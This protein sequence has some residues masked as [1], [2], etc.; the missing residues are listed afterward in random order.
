MRLNKKKK[1]KEKKRNKTPLKQPP[2]V[3]PKPSNNQICK[4]PMHLVQI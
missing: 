4:K 3:W 2:N 1:K